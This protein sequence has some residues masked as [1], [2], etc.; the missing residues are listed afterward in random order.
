MTSLIDTDRVHPVNFAAYTRAICAMVGKT[1]FSANV[2]M[3]GITLEFSG[4]TASAAFEL[5][6]VMAQR[7]YGLGYRVEVGSATQGPGTYWDS[8]VYV[9]YRR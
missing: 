7:I 5:A 1:N 6:T 4:Q 9:D 3:N 2:E 8:V